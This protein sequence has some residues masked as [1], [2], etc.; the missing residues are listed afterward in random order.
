MLQTLT[1]WDQLHKSVYIYIYITISINFR[2]NNLGGNI[3]SIFVGR[4]FEFN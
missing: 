2:L 4:E 1:F 3:F